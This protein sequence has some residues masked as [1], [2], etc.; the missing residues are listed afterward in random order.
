MKK[1]NTIIVEFEGMT[2]ARTLNTL[3]DF[4]NSANDST[5]FT[6]SRDHYG[7]MT[8]EPLFHTTMERMTMVEFYDGSCEVS[9]YMRNG[10]SLMAK[11][12]RLHNSKQFD[13]ITLVAVDLPALF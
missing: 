4:A 9:Y 10:S 7:I 2:K 13:T 8:Y 11:L 5:R 1:N 3:K 12:E 6:A